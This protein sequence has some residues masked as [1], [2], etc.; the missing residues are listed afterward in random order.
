MTIATPR[1]A[2][3]PAAGIL[4]LPPILDGVYHSLNAFFTAEFNEPDELLAG[5]HRR[6]VALLVSDEAQGKTHLLLQLALA[7]AGGQAV[8]P[9]SAKAKTPRRILYVNGGDAAARRLQS[10]L[11]KLVPDLV[12]ADAAPGN[13]QI[14]AGTHLHRQRLNLYCHSHWQWFAERVKKQPADLII[15]DGMREPLTL[16]G[17]SSAAARLE[18]LRNARQLAA[19]ADCAVVVACTASSRR[20]LL[21]TAQAQTADTVYTLMSDYRR[22]AE[23]RQWRC[24]QSRWVLPADLD[25][26]R[27]KGGRGYR[28]CQA[29]TKTD[30]HIPSRVEAVDVRR[31]RE[32]VRA[33]A[34]GQESDA[35][36]RESYWG[37]DGQHVE[38]SPRAAG[39]WQ[40]PE[41]R[42]AQTASGR[43]PLAATRF[44]NRAE[45]KPVA[46]NWQT[47]VT[48]RNEVAT[49][50]V[51]VAP[52]VGN[53]AVATLPVID[54][55]AK[56]ESGTSMATDEITNSAANVPKK[57]DGKQA[58]KRHNKKMRRYR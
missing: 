14:L 45:V 19:D 56:A 50:G 10:E 30:N 52:T 34:L 48:A 15:I 3:S 46:S 29:E 40:A 4:E 42:L 16:T 32:V 33:K 11:R 36:V 53:F 6:E 27:D 21:G 18:L 51:G 39:G 8:L 57:K 25:L 13:F 44:D 22:D 49:A 24:L 31:G 23:Y 35:P 2:L 5:L 1:L 26:Q 17:R 55:T 58:N 28:L 37:W 12:A 9:I 47:Q 7:L 43:Q 38:W 41:R 54:G 20:R